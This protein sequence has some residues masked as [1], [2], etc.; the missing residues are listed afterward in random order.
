QEF[1]FI[2]YDGK[3]LRMH[4]KVE[5]R[6]NRE[7]WRPLTSQLRIIALLHNVNAWNTVA[8]LHTLGKFSTLRLFKSEKKHAIRSLFYAIAEQVQLR[9]MHAL[10]AMA[11]WQDK[12]HIATFGTDADYW[13]NRKGSDIDMDS[14][15]SDLSKRFK[16]AALCRAAFTE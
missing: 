3:V 2:F 4:I 13:E 16:G 14:V 15:L 11:S 6:V 5:Y 12:W 1:D 8:L 9:S 10:Q 7:A